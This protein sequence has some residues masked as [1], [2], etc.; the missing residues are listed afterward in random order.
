MGTDQPK[1]NTEKTFRIIMAVLLAAII[2]LSVIFVFI[3]DQSDDVK[4]YSETFT[5]ISVHQAYNLINNTPGLMII[6]CRGMDGCSDCQYKKGHLEGSELNDNHLLYYNTT[7]DLL[8]YSKD[9]E[10]GSIFCSRL[11]GHVYGKIYNMEGGY[12]EWVA[13]GYPID[14]TTHSH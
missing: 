13:E 4:T 14:K 1:K 6:D 7:S 5:N 8:V 2:I 10:N 9:G 3:Y 11:V 12:L